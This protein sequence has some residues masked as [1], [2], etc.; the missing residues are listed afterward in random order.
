MAR[1]TISMTSG[2][3]KTKLTAA[4]SG[5]VEQTTVNKENRDTNRGLSRRGL[6][7]VTLAPACVLSPT[8]LRASSAVHWRMLSPWIKGRTGPSA[9]AQ[10]IAQNVFKMSGGRFQIDVFSTGE[11]SPPFAIFDSVA[12]GIAELGHAAS[13]YWQGKMPVAALFTTAPFGLSPEEHLVWISQGG[14]QDLWDE[15]YRP[16]GV[17]AFLAGNTGPSMGGWFKKKIDN[18][19]DLKGLRIRVQGMG[20]DVYRRLGALPTAIAPADLVP[21]LDKGIIDA[22]EF[23]APATDL[24]SNLHRLAPYYYAPGFNKPNGAS[25]LLISLKAWESLADDLREILAT[26][27]QLEHARGLASASA[28]NA[29]A[30]VEI[31]GRSPATV[32][33]FPDDVLTRAQKA[34]AEVLN[35]VAA[36]SALAGRIVESYRAMQRT[37]RPWS[38]LASSMERMMARHPLL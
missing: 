2:H 7:A 23:L 24:E 36:T 16:G 5:S 11:I 26:A 17:R 20:A 1:F 21:A 30:L 29:S 28:D 27:S 4:K 13:F 18:A 38:S 19:D 8:V 22:A 32:E 6:L 33:P 37:L 3:A 15:L 31:L 12:E 9:S 34:A 10:R 35:E 14:G 25:E